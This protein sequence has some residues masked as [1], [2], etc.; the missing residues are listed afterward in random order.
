MADAAD[1][2]SADRKVMRVRLPPCPPH[3]LS[4]KL[5]RFAHRFLSV[6]VVVMQY[7]LQGQNLRKS[8]GFTL[9]E[10]LVVIA[11]IAILAA[12]LFPIFSSA[13]ATAHTASCASNLKQIGIAFRAYLDDC[14]GLPPVAQAHPI[15]NTRGTS[16]YVS[17]VKGWT[18]N[19]Y[20]YTGNKIGIFKCAT[21]KVNFA[22]TYNG[23][24]GGSSN[25]SRAMNPPRPSK[26]IMVFES[27]GTGSG[28]I[29][30]KGVN[31][32]STGNADQTNEN[33]ADGDVYGVNLKYTS[34]D[35][36]ENYQRLVPE[37]A[38][39]DL[40]V[41]VKHRRHS[42]MYFPGP[43]QGRCNIMFFDG[44]VMGYRDWATGQM[45][46]IP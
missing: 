12:I 41:T 34:T 16:V 42:Q 11:I 43:H 1:L 3:K 23:S 10:L 35:A 15:F 45:T 31:A 28:N 5:I 25:G 26:L 33:Q 8:P 38:D 21:R 17:G 6:G 27:P 4:V 18:E 13:K 46:F 29:A 20:K 37:P 14:G 39:L 9:I 2:K 40:P 36:F 24:L 30:P 44:H 19:V 7:H 32:Y 22:Y